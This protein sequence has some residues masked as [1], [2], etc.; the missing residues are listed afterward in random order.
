[1]KSCVE[2]DDLLFADDV[3]TRY[4]LES[5]LKKDTLYQDLN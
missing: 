4:V 1:M 5:T 3:S 2:D